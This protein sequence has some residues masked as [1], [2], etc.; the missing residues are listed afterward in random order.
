V[1]FHAQVERRHRIDG[2]ALRQQLSES[3][4]HKLVEWAWEQGVTQQRQQRL[5]A[6]L[7]WCK[8]A[9]LVFQRLLLPRERVRTYGSRPM[10]DRA[11]SMQKMIGQFTVRSLDRV[12]RKWVEQRHKC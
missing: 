3:S 8:R 6:A 9:L 5:P 11:Q 10:H 2:V 12:A 7:V 1:C 4:C